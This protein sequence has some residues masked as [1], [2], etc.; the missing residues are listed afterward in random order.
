MD[1]D[2]HEEE[3]EVENGESELH[4]NENDNK[5]SE[6]ADASVLPLP[7]RKMSSDEEVFEDAKDTVDEAVT[8]E[9][10]ATEP[11]A[12]QPITITDTDD[13]TPIEVIK[14]DKTGRVKRDYSRRKRG[15]TPSI[16]KRSDDV[17]SSE[18]VSGIST[19]M[20]LKERERSESPYCD[21][22]SNE[23][24]SKTKRRCSSTPIIDSLPN[25]PASSDD[26]EYRGW[27]KSILI[28]Y[29]RLITHKNAS[30]FAK[31]ISEDH[32]PD[33]KDIVLQPMDLQTLKRN[34]ENG[35]IRT[36]LDFQRYVMVMCYNAIF[37]NFNDPLT[38]SMAEEMLRDALTLIDDIM[39]LWRKENDKSTSSSSA[40]T[41][42][43]IISRGRK[44][45]RL[46]A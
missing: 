19:R 28:V 5:E 9:E 7:D 10:V 39:E 22:E 6:S 23:P 31:P 38:C 13:E 29:N 20:K 34:I 26:R 25:S 14:E 4:N 42:T 43:K 24:A 37:Y 35:S 33:Y 12:Q 44:S 18:E 40:T 3:P 1:E 46:M 30:L 11:A 36:T 2:G 27:K 32:A 45:N 17:A 8:V 16:D 15:S 21:E 41:T